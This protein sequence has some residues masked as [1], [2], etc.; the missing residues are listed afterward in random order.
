M[1][2]TGLIS[3]GLLGTSLAGFETAVSD[4]ITLTPSQALLLIAFFLIFIFA[5]IDCFILH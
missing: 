5:L 2:G 4:Y 1:F 3:G